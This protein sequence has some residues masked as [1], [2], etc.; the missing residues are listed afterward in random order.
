MVLPT[1]VPVPVTTRTLMRPARPRTRCSASS[2]A[3]GV[4]GGEVRASGDAQPG[5][6]VGNRR[7]PEATDLTPDCAQIGWART[8]S[9][10]APTGPMRRPR[11]GRSTCNR[12]RGPRPASAVAVKARLGQLGVGTAPAGRGQRG[13]DGRRRQAGVEDERACGVDQVLDHLAPPATA[14][15]CV[16]RDLDK[17]KVRTTSGRP[18]CRPRPAPPPARPT[19]PR[20]WASSTMQDRVVLLGQCGSARPAARGRRR[21]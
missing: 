15:P 5:D 4:G 11:R 6:A 16:P 7:R 12:G 19:T 1:S 17:V 10:G 21:R 14:P 9:S 8:A 2:T 18:P 20:L 3:P 13:A